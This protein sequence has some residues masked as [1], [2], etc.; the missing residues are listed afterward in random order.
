MRHQQVEKKQTGLY[1]VVGELSFESVGLVEK[2][3]WQAIEE[4]EEN[5]TM[6]LSAVTTCSSAALALLLSWQ[7]HAQ[8][9]SKNLVFSQLPQQLRV[10]IQG[11]HVDELL[12][13][14]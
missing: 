7:R 2:E 13:I 11:A 8:K 9:H 5:I 4:V 12:V 6:D 3:G 10:L 14:H 1:G